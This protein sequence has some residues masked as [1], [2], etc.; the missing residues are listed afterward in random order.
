LIVMLYDGMNRFLN[1]AA[2]AIGQKD[3]E[4]AHANLHRTGQILLE[5][6]A[7]LREDKGGE[8]AANLKKIY[9]YCYERVVIANL[10]KDVSIIREIQAILT[11]LGEGWKGLGRD[12]VSIGSSAAGSRAIRITG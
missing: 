2:R 11:N 7:T 8:I 3:I 4:S 9:V 1:K 6:L 5:L 12:T 10:Q